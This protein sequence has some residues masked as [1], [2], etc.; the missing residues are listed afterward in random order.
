MKIKIGT[1]LMGATAGA[2]LMLCLVG[3]LSILSR[4]SQ[5]TGI[6]NVIYL[7]VGITVLLGTAGGILLT[8]SLSRPIKK[9][10]AVL[11]EVARGNLTVDVPE[12]RTGDE[13]EELAD[14]CREMLHRL[15]ELIARISQSAQEVNVTGEKMARAA[16][17]A[18]G[19]TSQVTL[20]IDEVA[21]GSAEQTRNI[22]DTVQFIKEFNGAI[23]Q[24]SLGAQSQAASVA[25]TSE[26]VNQMARV[27]ETVTANAQIVAA[28]ANKASEVAVRGGEIVNKTVSGMEQI[29]ETVNVS[30]EQIKNLGE[31]SQQIGEITQ[32][33]DGISE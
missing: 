23:S 27:I 11:K 19:V 14:A 9:L 4:R 8:I 1:K 5:W 25:Q 13:V 26:I 29:A 33:I 3:I 15:K 24:I 6:D 21:K 28:S 18:S 2:M 20:A 31:L 30:A 12:I 17:Q 7:V 10:R 32:L 22:N 16:K